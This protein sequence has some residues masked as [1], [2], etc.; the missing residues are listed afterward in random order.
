METLQDDSRADLMDLATTPMPPYA[1]PKPEVTSATFLRKGNH[2]LRSVM[3]DKSTM[4]Q[5]L[6]AAA[7]EIIS[8]PLF[9]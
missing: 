2:S 1:V 3:N 6:Y 9:V 8:P 5:V 4:V 7:L